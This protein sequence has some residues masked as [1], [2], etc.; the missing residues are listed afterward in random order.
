V[1]VNLVDRT[2]LIDP[3]QT[4]YQQIMALLGLSPLANHALFALAGFTGVA[5]LFAPRSAARILLTISCVLALCMPLYDLAS[6]YIR[7]AL[8]GRRMVDPWWPVLLF[9]V[10]SPTTLAI[11]GILRNVGR[12]RRLK[13]WATISLISAILSWLGISFLYLSVS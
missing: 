13:T 6:L 12:L 5:A 2:G 11:A 3:E 9:L 8:E 4:I 7:A 1:G 10:F